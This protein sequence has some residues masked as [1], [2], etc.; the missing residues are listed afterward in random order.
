MTITF[1]KGLRSTTPAGNPELK[2]ILMDIK[3]DK[4][5]SQVEKCHTDLKYKDRL[6][7]FTPTGVFNHRS[8]AG[9][10]SYNGII[11]LDID[12]VED[13]ELLKK[14]VAELRYVH[15]AFVTPSGKGLKVIIKTNA[16]TETYKSVEVKV[17]D[18][19]L[20]DCGAVRDNRCKDIAR[21][22]FVSH[23]PNLYYNED[24]YL[25]NLDQYVEGAEIG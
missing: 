4:Y 3:S 2:D 20:S 19:F 10:E 13:P 24:S 25:L 6:P 9:L 22:Q 12:H 18:Y 7:C 21:I 1:F 23:D 5:K 14:Q 8:I 11:C 16:T 17:A 15:A